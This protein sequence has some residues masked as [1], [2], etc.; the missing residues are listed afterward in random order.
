MFFAGLMFVAAILFVFV[1]SFYRGKT[2][3]QSQV[4]PDEQAT[5]PILAGGT[6]T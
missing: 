1:A 6:P 2:Y 5:E 4:L 3:L